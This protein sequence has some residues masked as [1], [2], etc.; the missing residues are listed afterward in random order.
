MAS[1]TD[2]VLRFTETPTGKVIQRVMARPMLSPSGKKLEF[3][4]SMYLT[5]IVPLQA[6]VSNTV[7]AL[8]A[9]QVFTSEEASLMNRKIHLCSEEESNHGQDMASLMPKFI[10]AIR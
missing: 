3:K 5:S 10:D 4:L 7:T 9:P 8:S 1:S 2:W 6:H